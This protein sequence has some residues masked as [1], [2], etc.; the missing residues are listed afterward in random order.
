MKQ[1]VFYLM[2]LFVFVPLQAQW[3]QTNWPYNFINHNDNCFAVSGT[4]LFVGNS[5]GVF[6]STDNGANWTSAKTGLP[7]AEV[8]AL[9][10]SPNGAGGTNIFAGIWGYGIFLSTN[11]GTNWTAVNTGLLNMYVYSLA[12]LGT[13]IISGTIDGVFISTNN[14]TNWTE[15]SNGVTNTSI[16]AFA[17]IG[18]NLFAGCKYG[19][20]V[21][22]SSD[23]GV[24]W[25]SVN[26]GLTNTEVRVLGVAPNGAGGTNL[27]AGTN[28]GVF[29]STNNGTSWS[30]SNSG[31]TNME[32]NAFAFSPNGAGG[33]NLFVGTNSGVFLSTNNG[34]SW[35]VAN[36]GLTNTYVKAL[37]VI[38]TNLFAGT[39]HGGVYLSTNNAAS[40]NSANNGL[41]ANSNIPVNALAVSD[42]NLFAGT[43]DG[44]FLSTN[45]GT[46]W[47]AANTGLTNK[48]VHALAVSPNG[49]GGTNLFV[50]TGNYLNRDSSGVFLSTD[51]GTHWS[52]ANSGLPHYDS[53]NYC[54]VN[55]ICAFPD[56]AGGS[57]LFA[58]TGLSG[59]G[60]QNYTGIF[61]ST[62]NGSSW[63]E[64][65][66][67]L[68][69]NSDIDG[70][71]YEPVQS[72]AV[73]GTNLFAG[74]NGG[75]YLST[76][77]GT[78]WTATNIKQ[79]NVRSLIVSD[80]NLFAGTYDGVFLSTNNGTSWTMVN[81]GLTN[82]STL[83][84]AI[85]G[86]NLFAGTYG[87][88]FLS[89]NNG[90]SWTAVDTGFTDNVVKAF[91]VCGTNLFAATSG[92]GVWRRPLSEMIPASVEL[93][94]SK[95]PEKYSLSQNYPNP[96]NPSTTIRYSL[97]SSATVKLAVYDLLGREIATL[98]N[99]E[100]SVGWKE[101]QW[102]ASNFASGM[103]LVRMSTNNFVGAKKILL[104]K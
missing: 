39:R 102:N 34:T 11:N 45:N 9:A 29:L 96:F 49:T 21:F 20:G 6:L 80:T 31:L 13:N 66:N 24:N 30:E 18:T 54:F 44:V 2:T 94:S 40:W 97:Q 73:S 4:N 35:T 99:E 7:N 57:N 10:V 41:T 19:G 51:N 53:A 82:I 77:N 37:A 36:N 98:V 68:P 81:N 38:G 27:F 90:T 69:D 83:S 70:G 89:T 91:V 92:S 12:V 78:N 46:I 56:G 28:G 67:G 55:V 15:A 60:S 33:T 16:N 25:I 32:T 104:M 26:S 75:V 1:F 3:V 74:I 22:L 65:N 62:N 88:V 84:F 64:V 95:L 17:V 103:Y 47:T 76:N 8:N 5:S 93:S 14:G 43:D 42:A 63:S 86:K 79:T 87:G 59:W 50:G 85:S 72:L 48:Y 100:Q 61:L 71:G 101:V 52:R 23:N 58:G